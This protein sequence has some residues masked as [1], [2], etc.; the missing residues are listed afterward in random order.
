[1][2]KRKLKLMILFFS[3]VLFLLF[4]FTLGWRSWKFTTDGVV[5]QATITRVDRKRYDTDGNEKAYVYVEYVVGS[6]TYQGSFST[7]Y[8]NGMQ[9]GDFVQIRYLLSNPD[10]FI[11]EE[12]ISFLVPALCLVVGFLCF[13]GGIIFLIRKE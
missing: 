6:Q 9:Q 4:S 10:E 3:A 7:R 13:G 11:Y 2:K 1:M 5:A 12:E 8:F